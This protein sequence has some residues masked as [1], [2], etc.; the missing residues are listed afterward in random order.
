MQRSA[1]L[2]LTDSEPLAANLTQAVRQTL[3]AKC[4]LRPDAVRMSCQPVLRAGVLCGLHFALRG[5][6]EVLLTAVWDAETGV[7]LCYGSRGERFSKS[8][9]LG[10]PEVAAAD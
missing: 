8:V 3:A 7:L 6:R 2:G 4:R 5:P 9:I 1:E 10:A